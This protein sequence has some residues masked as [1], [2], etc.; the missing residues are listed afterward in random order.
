MTAS[1]AEASPVIVENPGGKSPLLLLGDHAGRAIPKALG[2][3]GLPAEEMDRHI[4]WDIGIAGLGLRLAALL[5]ACFIRQRY[6]RLVI[7]C[8]RDPARPDA[9]PEISDRTPIPA[10]LALPPAQRRWRRDLVFQPYHDRIAQELVGR[11]RQ[12]RRSALVAL[13]SFTPVMSGVARQ[14][15]Y[16]VLHNNDSDLSRAVLARLRA[17]AGPAAVGDNEPYAMDGVDFTVPHH[18]GGHGLD[19]VE[20]EI[21]QDLIAD[22]I[23]QRK[24]AT[25]LAPVLLSAM[26]DVGG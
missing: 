24:A 19:Y 11:G 3:M 6:S 13:H 1:V 21:R 16:G 22:D 17:E 7:D 5:D 23:G 25:M 20:L 2:D 9:I 15:R 12:G 18:A 26:A 8:N 4:A 10:N 14:W